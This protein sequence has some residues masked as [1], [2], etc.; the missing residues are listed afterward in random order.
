[1]RSIRL[2]KVIPLTA[3]RVI[4]LVS[5]RD[6]V[7]FIVPEELPRMFRVTGLV[8]LVPDKRMLLKRTRTVNQHAAL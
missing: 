2:R 6:Q 1:M 8:I 3:D 5:V 4:G 7:S